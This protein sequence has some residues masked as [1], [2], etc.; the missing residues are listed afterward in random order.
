MAEAF[1]A[2]PPG[3]ASTV[4]IRDYVEALPGISVTR[5]LNYTDGST[6]TL[7]VRNIYLE[8]SVTETYAGDLPSWFFTQQWERY[9]LVEYAGN[10]LPGESL[11]AGTA[12]TAG[13]D[14][15][16]LEIVNSAGTTSRN[17]L[18]AVVTGAGSP[19]AGQSRID[20]SDLNDFFEL[21]NADGGD[22][23]A[24]RRVFSTAPS[25]NDQARI[26]EPAPLP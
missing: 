7:D 6:G 26:V 5:A 15:V 2:F 9:V 11:A 12:C 17:D 22:R 19:L 23:T 21:K 13:T 1:L 14:C 20:G 16:N 18:F 8:P 10:A 24:E 25:F 4:T 3:S